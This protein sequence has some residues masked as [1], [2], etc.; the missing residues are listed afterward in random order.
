MSSFWN[1]YIGIIAVANILA[2]VWLI[3]WT[4]KKRPDERAAHETTG[5]EWDGLTELNNP[6]PRWWLWLFYATIVFGLIY[7]VLYP[8]F[9]SYQGLLGWSQYSEWEQEVAE[10][11]ERVAPLFEEYAEIPIPELAQ[12]SDAMQTGRRLFDNNCAVCHG[13]DGGGRPGFPNIANNV[14]NWGGEPEQI[15]TSILDGRR[16]NMPALGDALGEDGLEQVAA[17]TFSLSGRDAPEELVS[18]GEELYQQRCAACHQADGSGNPA[19]GA[20]NLTDDNWM[21]GGSLEAIKTSIREGR[22][23]VMPAQKDLLGEDRV[24]VLA[25]YVYS[26]SMD[27]RDAETNG[28]ETADAGGNE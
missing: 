13:V 10:T 6:M 21:Y 27:E 11:E 14:W 2:C 7:M 24:H 3:R 12:H 22:R 28:E 19:M 8:S 5:H 4:A 1:W 16:G 17:Y 25:A 26:L 20:P 9:G 18:A 15:Y 23:G